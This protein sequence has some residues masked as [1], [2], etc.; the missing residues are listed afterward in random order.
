MTNWHHG[1]LDPTPYVNSNPKTG[2]VNNTAVNQCRLKVYLAPNSPSDTSS[3]ADWEWLGAKNQGTTSPKKRKVSQYW[4]ADLDLKTSDKVIIERG[5][6]LSDRQMEA[7]HIV[8]AEQFP[9]LRGLQ[10]TNIGLRQLITMERFSLW[11]PL[12]WKSDSKHWGAAG[13]I[14]STSSEKQLPHPTADA[15]TLGSTYLCT[16]TVNVNPQTH[17]IPTWSSVNVVIIGFTSNV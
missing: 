12:Y 8:L 15:G 6:K 1:G 9:H 13:E 5:R 17:T 7:A 10:S 16:F 14:L 2:L 11:K 3:E 4:V